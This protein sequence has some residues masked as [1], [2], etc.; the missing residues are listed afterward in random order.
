MPICGSI[1]LVG[2]RR[3]SGAGC[4]AACHAA[5]ALDGRPASLR[6]WSQPRKQIIIKST[7]GGALLGRAAAVGSC[8][9]SWPCFFFCP[10]RQHLM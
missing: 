9:D 10:L 1:W 3:G 2:R 8:A 6:I 7:K 4:A 5:A